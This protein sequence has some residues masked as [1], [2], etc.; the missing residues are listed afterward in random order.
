L[1]GTLLLALLRW[2]SKSLFCC[3]REKFNP[4]IYRFNMMFWVLVVSEG[5][6]RVLTTLR[7]VAV[8]VM[9]EAAA[10]YDNRIGDE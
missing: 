6:L 5:F 3:A 10:M 9:V 8:V 7:V 1:G 2:V 4:P